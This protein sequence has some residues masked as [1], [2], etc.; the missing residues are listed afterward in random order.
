MSL[1]DVNDNAPIF[2][3][4]NYSVSIPENSDPGR[5]IA[6]LRAEDL[7]SEANGQLSYF[8]AAG[9]L[10][11]KF[12]GAFCDRVMKI[13]A[14][15]CSGEFS[16]LADGTVV[17]T[18]PLDYERRIQ[19]QLTVMATDGGFPNLSATT[20]LNVTILDVNDNAPFIAEPFEIISVA[21]VCSSK[22]FTS[23]LILNFS[24][25]MQQLGL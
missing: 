1:R 20:L 11:G 23:V 2:L 7:D 4:A 15:S 3:S 21:E 12:R 22:K 5:I 24:S 8:I 17:V 18:A 6:V 19:Y 25:R 9:D 16:V 13:V 14:S 10:D